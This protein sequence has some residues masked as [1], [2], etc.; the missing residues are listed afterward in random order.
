MRTQIPVVVIVIN[1]SPEVKLPPTPFSWISSRLAHHSPFPRF[2][3]HFIRHLILLRLEGNTKT[4]PSHATNVTNVTFLQTTPTGSTAVVVLVV[5]V[6]VGSY[7]DNYLQVDTT[8]PPLVP[9]TIEPL[10]R[11]AAPYTNDVNVTGASC[12]SRQQA[13]S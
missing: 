2:L 9:P 6:V 3:H 1:F 13:F 7:P 8:P 11:L 4:N 12:W 10:T 5:V